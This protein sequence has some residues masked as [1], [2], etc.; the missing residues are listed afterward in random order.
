MLAG[1]GDVRVHQGDLCKRK[2]VARRCFASIE[3]RE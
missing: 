2:D 1:K 3:G